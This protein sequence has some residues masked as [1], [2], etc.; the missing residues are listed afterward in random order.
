MTNKYNYEVMF[1]DQPI[2]V[3]KKVDGP[4]RYDH[5]DIPPYKRNYEIVLEKTLEEK[6]CCPKSACVSRKYGTFSPIASAMARRFQ[7]CSNLI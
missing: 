6:L 5:F 2:D 4:P 1:D 7:D 3:S